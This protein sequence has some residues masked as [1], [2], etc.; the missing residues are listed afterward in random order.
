MRSS[1]L[2]ALFVG[3]LLTPACSLTVGPVLPVVPPPPDVVPGQLLF[4]VPSAYVEAQGVPSVFKD[5]RDRLPDLLKRDP[6]RVRQISSR[7]IVT[8]MSSQHVIWA[9]LCHPTRIVDDGPPGSHIML[10]EQSTAF[11]RG[12]YWVRTAKD[13]TV[14]SAGRF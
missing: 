10:W 9:F 3:L 1:I 14:W 8:G 11:I 2:L 5:R 7:E 13:G 6:E 12:R 4:V